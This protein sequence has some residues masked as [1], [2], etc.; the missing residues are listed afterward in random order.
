MFLFTVFFI[1]MNYKGGKKSA[2]QNVDEES[3]ETNNSMDNI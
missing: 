1:N 2:P 3:N